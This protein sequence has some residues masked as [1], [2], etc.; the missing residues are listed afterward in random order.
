MNLEPTQKKET[1]IRETFVDFP[2]QRGLS[3][4]GEPFGV[5]KWKTERQKL[6]GALLPIWDNLQIC[7]SMFLW[8]HI[9]YFHL[10]QKRGEHGGE[11]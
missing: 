9:N 7:E 11:K 5:K 2:W 6:K 4:S 1:S 10:N 8:V 3:L